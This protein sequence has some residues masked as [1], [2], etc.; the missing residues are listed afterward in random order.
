MSEFC[1]ISGDLGKLGIPNLAQMFLIK[2]YSMLQ[3]ARVIAFSVSQLLWENQHG[4]VKLPP[5]RLGLKRRHRL[6]DRFEI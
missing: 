4:R 2:C 6:F 1:P 5:P 3:N